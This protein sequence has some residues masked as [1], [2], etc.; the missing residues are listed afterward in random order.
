[1]VL[2]LNFGALSMKKSLNFPNVIKV[3][4][5]LVN[6]DMTE[7]DKELLTEIVEHYLDVFYD[8]DMD[9]FDDK[10]FKENINYVGERIENMI[11]VEEIYDGVFYC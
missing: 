11:S 4:N 8:P 2:R 10:G 3:V 7:N 1:M 9:E 5:G 6:K